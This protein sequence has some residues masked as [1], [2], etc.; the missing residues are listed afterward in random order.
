MCAV[1]LPLFLSD[2]LRYVSSQTSERET[3]RRDARRD[4]S[5]ARS[6]PSRSTA[7]QRA[8][9][10]RTAE[11]RSGRRRDDSRVDA[12]ILVLV[13]IHHVQYSCN[14]AN[15]CVPQFGKAAKYRPKTRSIDKRRSGPARHAGQRGSS[16]QCNYLSSSS[17]SNS[18]VLRRCC[19]LLSR[20]SSRRVS[21]PD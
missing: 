11:T 10:G 20:T 6:A 12:H 16:L 19:T 17:S 2:S 9:S 4:E 15:K 7:R 3:T 21:K 1:R 14:S 18:S 13:F 8:E 5:T